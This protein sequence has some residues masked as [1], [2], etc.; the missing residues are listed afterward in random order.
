M[1]C[2]LRSRGKKP[3]TSHTVSSQNHIDLLTSSNKITFTENKKRKKL[4][5]CNLGLL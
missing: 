5:S 4:L 3:E 1:Q 2:T